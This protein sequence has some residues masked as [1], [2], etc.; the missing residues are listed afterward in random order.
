MLDHGGG[1]LGKIAVKEIPGAGTVT[2]VYAKDPE[3]N[4]VELQNWQKE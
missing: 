3:G 4:V 1:V 2:F